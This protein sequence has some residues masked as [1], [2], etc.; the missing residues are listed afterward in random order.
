MGRAEDKLWQIVIEFLS[1][2]PD[3]QFQPIVNELAS[4]NYQW[5]FLK[6]MRLSREQSTKVG[7]A[8]SLGLYFNGPVGFIFLSDDLTRILNPSEFKFVIGHEMSHIAKSHIIARYMALLFEEFLVEIFSRQA[9]DLFKGIFYFGGEKVSKVMRENELEADRDAANLIG[10]IDV[11]IS[12]LEKLAQYY[13]A[14][15]LGA[16]SHFTLLAKLPLPIVTFR[17]RINNLRSFY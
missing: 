13:A 7:P 17:E 10:S 16:S 8:A 14:G 12:A 11:G 2:I 15:N 9:V 5:H 1:A 3:Q 4:K 6:A